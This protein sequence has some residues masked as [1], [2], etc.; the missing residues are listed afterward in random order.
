MAGWPFYSTNIRSRRRKPERPN[1]LSVFAMP[2]R[3]D[4][5][6]DMGEAFRPQKTKHGMG[7][8]PI[9]I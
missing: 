6:G 2:L 7:V 8:P 3:L 4:L 5:P 1:I 9:R